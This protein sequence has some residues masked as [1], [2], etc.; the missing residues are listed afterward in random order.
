MSVSRTDN[1]WRTLD[2]VIRSKRNDQIRFRRLLAPVFAFVVKTRHDSI[3]R[4]EVQQDSGQRQ[5]ERVVVALPFEP[6]LV[7]LG[8]FHRMGDSL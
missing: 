6:L 8:P 7:E 3:A 1:A 5:I 2:G 4:P